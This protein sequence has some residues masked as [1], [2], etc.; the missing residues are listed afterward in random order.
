MKMKKF[1]NS[2]MKSVSRYTAWDF[3]ILKI[4][5]FSAGVI[6]GAYFPQ[7][8]L[9]NIALVWLVFIITYAYIMYKT[10]LKKA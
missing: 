9:R 3:G 6:L 10:F 5:L 1:M 7:F 8:F 4:C 2:A